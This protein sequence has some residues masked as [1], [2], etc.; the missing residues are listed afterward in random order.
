MRTS[1]RQLAEHPRVHDLRWPVVVEVAV[2]LAIDRP[3][4]RHRHLVALA[5]VAA[6]DTR[7]KRNSPSESSH[8]SS[9]AIDSAISP[10]SVPVDV[11]PSS[12]C[13]TLWVGMM[14]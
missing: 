4:E 1:I 2:L 6:A 5:D 9:D 10:M 7:A 3:D 12:S 8:F 11:S 13:G 14:S